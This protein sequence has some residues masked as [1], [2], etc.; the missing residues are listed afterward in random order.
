ML[1]YPVTDHPPGT[2]SSV[3]RVISQAAGRRGWIGV[4]QKGRNIQESKFRH[5]VSGRLRR[6]VVWLVRGF[7]WPKA[8]QGSVLFLRARRHT[9]VWFSG[10]MFKI[11]LMACV[12]RF[13]DRIEDLHK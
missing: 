4:P 8:S 3:I 11:N 13:G 6:P 2:A 5:G 10:L 12:G 7:A 1:F 9:G